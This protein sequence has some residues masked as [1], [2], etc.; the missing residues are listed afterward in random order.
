VETKIEG[1]RECFAVVG[2]GAWLGSAEQ[3]LEL[4]REGEEL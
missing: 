2:I 3:K 4:E 1:V